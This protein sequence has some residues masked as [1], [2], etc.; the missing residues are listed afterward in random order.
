MNGRQSKELFRGETERRNSFTDGRFIA[1]DV[2]SSS[3]VLVAC[4]SAGTDRRS[5]KV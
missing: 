1:C 4:L 5:G 2:R 3:S